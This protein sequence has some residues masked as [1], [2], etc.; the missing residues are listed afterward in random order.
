MAGALVLVGGWRRAARSCRIFSAMQALPQLLVEA[1][2]SAP[3]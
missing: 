1:R 2:G 3:Q